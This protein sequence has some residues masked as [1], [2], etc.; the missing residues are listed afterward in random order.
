MTFR[1]ENP[2]MWRGEASFEKSSAG[3]ADILVV[4]KHDA[5]TQNSVII[6]FSTAAATIPD[7]RDASATLRVPA[8]RPLFFQLTPVQK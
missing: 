7:P 5:A 6:V 3:D 8:Y 1:R 4:R 2:A